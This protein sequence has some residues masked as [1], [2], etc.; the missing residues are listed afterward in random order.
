M[1]RQSRKARMVHLGLV[2]RAVAKGDPIEHVG[3]HHGFLEGH[4]SEAPILDGLVLPCFFWKDRSQW[5][6]KRE[7][8]FWVKPP[9]ESSMSDSVEFGLA[10]A[11]EATASR[12]PIAKRMMRRAGEVDPERGFGVTAGAARLGR[13]SIDLDVVA[14]ERCVLGHRKII[15]EPF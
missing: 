11:N 5:N 1:N 2:E 9:G 10:A 12:H 3:I 7:P 8:N 15:Y 4:G 13:S 6:L 14:D